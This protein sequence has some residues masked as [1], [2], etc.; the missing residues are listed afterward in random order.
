MKQ[1]SALLLFAFAFAFH[2]QA[3][4]LVSPIL[5]G[6]LSKP[7]NAQ[8]LNPCPGQDAG[9]IASFDAID[10]AS[11]DLDRDTLFLCF[12]DQVLINHAGDFDLS[13]DPNS[14]TEGGVA[15]AVY[16][17][18]PTV[19][20]PTLADIQSDPS[21][22]PNPLDPINQ[23]IVVSNT[24]Q[25][26]D[27]ED[28][29]F[30]NDGAIQNNLNMGQPVVLWFAPITA[31]AF[32]R[33]TIAGTELLV[34]TYE[35][36]PDQ[37]GD[38]IGTCVS[39]SIDEAFAIVY[40][41][42]I[43]NNGVA[44]D[45]QNLSGSFEL[46]GGLPQIQA[47][48]TY[49]IS[50]VN[51]ENP[52]LTGTV[53]SGAT[54]HAE[55]VEVSVPEAGVYIV[56]VED[57]KS[58][59]HSFEI[60]ISQ[61]VEI[62]F[63]NLNIPQD[64]SGCV[65]V[66]ARNFTNVSSFQFAFTWNG[67]PFR[68]DSITNLNPAFVDFRVD[69]SFNLEN[70]NQDAAEIITNWAD[71][72]TF[73][74]VTLDEEEV[75]FS[76]CF[77]GRGTEGDCSTLDI[78]VD[79]SLA[80]EVTD[81]NGIPY[82]LD[83]ISGQVCISNS[84]FI[85]TVTPTP[86]D[87]G[88][89]GL[90]TI[91]FVPENGVAPYRYELLDSNG[92]VIA[93]GD[94]IGEGETVVIDDLAADTYDLV[95]FDQT[96]NPGVIEPVTEADIE[97]TGGVNFGVSIDI[98][99]VPI[100]CNGAS[101][102]AIQII[103]TE[104]GVIVPNPEDNYTFVWSTGDST[105]IVRDIG[106]GDYAVTVSNGSCTKESSA[107]VSQ[108]PSIDIGEPQA[109]SRDATCQGIN[110]GIIIVPVSGGATDQTNMYRYQWNLT[111][112]N[113]VAVGQPI[114]LGGLTGGTYTLTV[115]DDN[116]CQDSS[117]F[118]VGYEKILSVAEI[119]QDITCFGGNDGLLEITASTTGGTEEL[120]YSFTWESNLGG[121]LPND[122]PQ[123][124]Q[125]EGLTAGT[126]TLL[127][128]DNTQVNTPGLEN[129]RCFVRETFIL[130]Q[131]DRIQVNA[132]VTNATCEGGLNDGQIILEEPI[133]GTA[134]F[135]YAWDSL[136]NINDRIV[137]NLTTGEY[138]VVLTD[139]N[140][141]MDSV[142]FTITAPD[143]PQITGIEQ[144]VLDCA[145]DM[146]GQLTVQ[147]QN[148]TSG[149]LVNS[150]EWSNGDNTAT[151]DAD[152]SPGAYIVTITDA[153]N[154]FAIDTGFVVAPEPLQLDS[155]ITA[156][157][158]CEGR[159]DGSLS[160]FASG[161]T[162][163][164]IYFLNGENFPDSEFGAL[165]AG[166]YA[167]EV[168]DINNC[169]A[170]STTATIENA[171]SILVSFVDVLATDC[172]E[173]QGTC[174]GSATAT[175]VLSTGEERTFDFQWNN[176]EE[177]INTISS[178]AT[179]LCEGTNLLRVTDDGNNGCNVEV[180]VEIESPP[181]IQPFA[182]DVS[183]VSC[184]GANDGRATIEVLGGTPDFEFF[185]ENGAR[186]AT[187]TDL[188]PG[189]YNLRVVDANNCEEPFR[190]VIEEPEVLELTISDATQSVTCAG[191]EDGF[192]QLLV[193]GGNPLGG[194]PFTW[195]DGIAGERDSLAIDLAPGTYF[196]TVVDTR[197][198]TD[199]V[200]Y[201]IN[202]PTPVMA[203]IPTPP[204]PAC[205]GFQT[206]IIVTDASGGAGGPYSFSV[207][208]LSKTTLAGSIPVFGG[209]EHIVS[210]FDV[211]GCS[212]DTTLFVNQPPPVEIVLP[213]EIEVQ[214]GDSVRLRPD[215]FSVVPIDETTIL[216]TPNDFLSTT[217]EL[218]PTIRP[219][220]AGEYTLS[221]ADVNGCVGEASIFVDVDKKRNVYIPNVIAPNSI[222]NNRFEIQ[223]GAGVRQVNFMRIY[224]R[225][226]S[227]IYELDQTGPS[228]GG[229]GDWDGTFN[230]K[231]LPSATYVYIVEVEFE[232]DA[233]LLYRGD[234]T[235]IY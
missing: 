199:S 176:G 133:G 135:T 169:P 28:V 144:D 23:I 168:I 76:I 26:N 17:D 210:V 202:E 153:N 138:K 68:F 82:Q 47:D 225:W 21:I 104:D 72:A 118:E 183:F 160:I 32:T 116:G 224:D 64:G 229:I 151:T 217:N 143:V 171:P 189:T 125:L 43:R 5:E 31:D 109:G 37:A 170:V 216:W 182:S 129:A 128:E 215:V 203:T 148:G 36:D 198:C 122:A 149:A 165:P 139:A 180:A 222:R 10:A 226:G 232:D 140:N 40:L 55:R 110:D 95:V 73:Q 54:G 69:N 187:L 78:D 33:R 63:T 51:R 214:L 185:W 190:I 147:F 4:H 192:I 20:G 35:D 91:S 119:T 9:T 152:L 80:A 111:A 93:D 186:T 107:S 120:P 49:T 100:T 132:D 141:C 223:T 2:A 146:D 19:A 115:T 221:L 137:E 174:T 13:G 206:S 67:L 157:P 194:A 177:S 96:S 197:G 34:P 145:S 150:F 75:L 179:S 97:L 231:R 175:A 11:N 172:N 94:N 92:A 173:E 219:I 178:T 123:S 38:I 112:E 156:R 204:E 158:T 136:P 8:K 52:A 87:C 30:T 159:A 114:Q 88:T 48:A 167:I 58:C 59:P 18:R 61:G 230:G 74:T 27:I 50:V 200:S 41:N 25:V 124:T 24:V 53:T 106:S 131:P 46:G 218:N 84:A 29:V 56:T 62:E 1:L 7:T 99:F 164:Y 65:D 134:P 113:E 90:G 121:V 142:V 193:N 42:S 14:D 101:D 77:S 12:G 228:I 85:V 161:G 191:D 181:L 207:N 163:P 234:V 205:F 196:A 83:V 86:A 66:L 220:R 233:T 211:R 79:R 235:I 188:A 155:I 127:V 103:I 227:L 60:N 16:S 184:N 71:F 126:Y 22:I 105:A 213:A 3:Q 6:E 102:G 39:V 70:A 166:E 45:F 212:F 195:S 44:V 154:C 117:S 98:D 15:Y 108:P 162:A 130:T 201:T 208:N 81:S 89:N 209:Q 57:G